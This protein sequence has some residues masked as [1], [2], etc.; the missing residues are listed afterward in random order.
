MLGEASLAGRAA[1]KLSG[2]AAM[3]S[4]PFSAMGSAVGATGRMAGKM[5]TGTQ[6]FLTGKPQFAFQTAAKAGAASAA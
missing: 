2:A 5:T 3:A 6:Q 1:S 4:N